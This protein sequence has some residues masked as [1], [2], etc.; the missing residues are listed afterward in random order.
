MEVFESIYQNENMGT[1][2]FK[3]KG[4][5][6]KKGTLST[7]LEYYCNM[8]KILNTFQNMIAIFKSNSTDF[9]GGH[10]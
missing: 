10:M 5:L 3:K 4:T 7:E 1:D 6:F 2:V 8:G 9:R